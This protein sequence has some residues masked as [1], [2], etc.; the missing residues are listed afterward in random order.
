[1]CVLPTPEPVLRLP[2]D[3]PTGPPGEGVYEYRVITIPPD[4]PGSEVRRALAEHAEY[5]H[6][7]LARV[8][9]FMGGARRIWIRRRIIR[10]S[11][12]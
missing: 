6:W 5:G 11:R 10:V 7:E 9:R 3:L 2:S 8:R 4:V 12:K 1:M